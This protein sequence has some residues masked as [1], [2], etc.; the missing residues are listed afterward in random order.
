MLLGSCAAVSPPQS[1]VPSE[2]APARTEAAIP[3]ALPQPAAR[4]RP[5]P[6][7][8]QAITID[9]S[10]IESF[11][12]SWER[13]RAT[14]SPAQQTDLTNAVVRLTFA[15]YGGGTDMPANL[16]SSPIVPEMIRDRI[17]GLSYAEI[18]VLPP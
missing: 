5:T 18:I 6:R 12:A 11:R 8:P 14:L 3:E 4:S 10:S 2:P 13:M 16:R 1:D 15:R 9:N 7:R 17:A